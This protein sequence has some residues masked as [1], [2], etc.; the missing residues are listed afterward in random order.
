MYRTCTHHSVE[1]ASTMSLNFQSNIY[2]APNMTLCYDPCCYDKILVNH[3]LMSDLLLPWNE[4]LRTTRLDAWGG[5]AYRFS[6]WMFHEKVKHERETVEIKVLYL[7]WWWCQQCLKQEGTKVFAICLGLVCVCMCVCVWKPPKTVLMKLTMI[8]FSCANLD[9][10][11]LGYLSTKL[12]YKLHVHLSPF[13][14]SS[15]H[16]GEHCVC[17]SICTSISLSTNISPL[18]ATLIGTYCETFVI[19]IHALY[20]L[21]CFVLGWMWNKKKTQLDSWKIHQHEKYIWGNALHITMLPCTARH[22][23]G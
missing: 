16:C 10:L 4:Y 3:F 21:T 5:E 1:I 7:F 13:I 14:S 11:L 12:T 9:M 18:K 22:Y 2:N 8:K 20:A 15:Q 23:C 6:C 19:L 17:F